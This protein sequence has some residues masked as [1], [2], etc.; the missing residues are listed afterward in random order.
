MSDKD[1]IMYPS[2]KEILR[3]EKGESDFADFSNRISQIGSR[4][5]TRT[6]VLVDEIR[7]LQDSDMEHLAQEILHKFI[8]NFD[9]LEK[10]DLAER[11]ERLSKE[12]EEV[13]RVCDDI[14][15]IQDELKVIREQIDSNRE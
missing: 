13:E 3:G 5:R 7:L 9:D 8:E 12:I 14:P 11:L 1:V 6:S 2:D 15:A 4:V 10:G